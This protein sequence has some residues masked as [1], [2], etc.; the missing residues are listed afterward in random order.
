[1]QTIEETIDVD[2]P[3]NTVYNQW[4]QFEDFPEFMEDVQEV[5]QLDDKRVHWVATIA[6]KRQEWD[7]EIVEQVPDLRI[8]WRAISGKRNEGTVTFA[9]K[10]EKRTTVTVR[11]GYEPDGVLE[12][13]AGAVGAASARVKGDLKRFKDFIESRRVETGAWRGEIHGREVSREGEKEARSKR[14]YDSDQGTQ[15]TTP[16]GAPGKM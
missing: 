11:L 7:A 12:T 14:L 5:R 10:G 6:G 8:S 4:T 9:S 13:V 1:M 15:S 3:L 2:V 16:G